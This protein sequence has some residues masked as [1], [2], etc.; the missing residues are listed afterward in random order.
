[1]GHASVGESADT[2][3]TSSLDATRRQGTASALP[4]DRDTDRGSQGPRE[5]A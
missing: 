3:G 5:K 2:G 1:M 4:E